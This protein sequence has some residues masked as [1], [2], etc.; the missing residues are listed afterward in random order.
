MTSIHIFS[1]FCF[2]RNRFVSIFVQTPDILEN[3]SGGLLVEGSFDPLN[4]RRQ[5]PLSRL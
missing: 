4:V 2:L 1:H 5:L 3:Y